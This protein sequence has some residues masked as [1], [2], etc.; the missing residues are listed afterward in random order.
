MLVCALLASGI[1][2]AFAQDAGTLLREQ[3]RRQQAPKVERLPAPAIE[4]RKPQLPE[5]PE[6]GPV[7]EVR[8]I[9]FTGK[10][11]LLTQ[12]E[13]VAFVRQVQGQRLGIAG[14]G[15]LTDEI[16]EALQHKGALL[17]RAV[18]PPQDITGG[19]VTIDI[20]EG[21]LE[22]AEY[23]R[24]KS[25]RVHESLLDGF[26]KRDVDAQAPTKAELESALLGM[27]ALP[28]VTVRSRLVPGG[29]PDT[30]RLI[31]GVQEAPRVSATLGGDNAGTPSTGSAEGSATVAFTDLTGF[32][33]QTRLS[34]VD[35]QGQTFGQADF[36]MPIGSTGLAGTASYGYLDYRNLTALGRSANLRGRAQFA[37]A[38]LAYS[39]LRS[40]NLDLRL[41]GVANWSALIDDSVAGQLDDKRIGS[42]TFSLSA[43]TRDALLG[44]GLSALNLA[45]TIGNLDLSRNASSTAADAA[46]LRTQGNFQRVNASATRIQALPSGFSLLSRF[47]GQWSNKNLDTSESFVLGGPYGV[48]AYPVGEARGDMGWL[49]TLE[50]RYDVPLASRLGQFQLVSF[51]D[52]GRVWIDKSPDGVPP[53]NACGC[54]AYDLYGAGLG[55]RW[56]RKD[57]SFSVTWARAL[58]SNPG[59]AIDGTNS[60]GGRA[61][62][63]L[64]L[65][66]AIQ[67]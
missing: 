10:T 17:A 11:S 59:R 61:R 46:G 3:E 30:S 26:I 15:K 67:F 19:I 23:E 4:E 40:R 51:V 39:L 9:R 44:G 37:S 63:Q 53:A 41:S 8:D 50:L 29:A 12:A 49:G 58:G 42:G 64:W 6:A 66:G 1:G 31:V 62:Q 7:V 56:T 35:S 18:I 20:A 32:G 38:G 33:D 47:T 16:T 34:T 14:L 55:V 45:W 36:S 22:K 54:N 5:T 52:G 57:L 28:G 27:N 25:V 13:R 21:R 48:R 43:D 60:D 65:Q 2:D 24:A